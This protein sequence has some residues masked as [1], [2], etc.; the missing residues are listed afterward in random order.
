V[1]LRPLAF[2]EILDGG[3]QAIRTNPRTMMGFAAV[4]LAITSVI[5]LVP[6]AGLQKL[7]GESASRGLDAADPATVISVSLTST[8]AA[9]PGGLITRLALIVLEAMLVVAV[10]AAVLGERTSPGQLWQRVRRRVP[11]AI[12]LAL[13]TG[14]IVLL[15]TTLA[16][17]V[18][19]VPAALAFVNDQPV[20]G[21]VLAL[22]TVVV[23]LVVSVGLWVMFALGPPALLL[24]NIGVLAAIRRSWRLVRGSFWRTLGVLLVAELLVGFV[25]G[26]IVLPFTFI[27]SLIDNG[28]GNTLHTD[29]LANLASASVTAIGTTVVGAVLNPWT[30]AVIALVYLDLRMR[31]E[32]LDLELIRTVDARAEGGTR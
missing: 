3:F 22:L 16:G 14:L 24:E 27:A 19:G 17:A 20:I 13:L 28:T 9:I 32:G 1:P 12:G 25:S 29:F 5:T 26:V 10:S 7:L 31:R 15:A 18:F 11:A 21:A 23:V 8:L 4:V 6:Q 30:A 2:G